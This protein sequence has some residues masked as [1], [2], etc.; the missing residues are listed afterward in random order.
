MTNQWQLTPEEQG[1]L[2]EFL[3][4]LVQTQ[5][6]SGRE[7]EVAALIMEEM[8][9]LGFA[10]VWMDDAGNVLGRIG[11]PH[12][13]M[14]MLNSHMDTV[15]V[16]SLDAWSTP[17]WAA[18]VRNGR[19]YGRGACDMK[20]GIAATL[21]GAA[22]LLK[23]NVPLQ[24]QVLVACVGLEEPSEG[25]CTRIL[26]E[27]E[28]IRPDWVLIAEPSNMQ[29]VR[30]QRGHVEMVLSVKGRSAHSSMPHLGENAIYAASR[31]IFGL[32]LLADQLAEDAFLGPGVLAVTDIRSHAVSRNAVPDLC[33]IV[34]DRRLTVGETE[35]LSL[36]E[37]QRVITREGVD[38]EV[39]VIED[40]VCTHTGKI[41]Q[42][43][44]A[45]PPWVLDE[46]HP[47]VQTML[48]AVRDVGVR[49]ALTRWDFATEGTYTAG[50]AQVPTVGFGPGDPDLAHTCDEYVKLEQVYTAASVYAAMA[51]R[52]LQG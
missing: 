45:S 3:R 2:L 11:E 10:D 6:L 48:D 24:G 5:S 30:A 7:Q 34:V 21:H 31:L 35:S 39:H 36:L 33:E 1:A 13:P 51:A 52:L 19:M 44:R 17:P 16:S 49:P 40:E 22:L 47:L 23:R 46:R 43:R 15:E 41:C 29:V 20:A 8:H 27:E 38:A 25:T 37:I 50:V 9:R 42:V 14:L 12:G 32:E 26:F 4:S 28:G 18:E